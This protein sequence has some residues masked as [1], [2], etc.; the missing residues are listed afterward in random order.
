MMREHVED[1][2]ALL[3]AVFLDLFSDHRFFA[4]LVHTRLVFEIT[5]PARLLDGPP[6]ENARYLSHV[7]LRVAAVDTE[8]VQFHQLAAVIFVQTTARPG[9]L[10]VR[11]SMRAVRGRKINAASW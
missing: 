6:G 11:I 8:R 7:L 10:R 5:T 4:R 2:H 3:L 1:F 9:V